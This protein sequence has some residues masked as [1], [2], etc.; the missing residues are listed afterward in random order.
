LS[1]NQPILSAVAIY[2]EYYGSAFP[3]KSKRRLRKWAWKRYQALKRA[4]QQAKRV[5]LLAKLVLSGAVSFAQVIDWFLNSQLVLYMG[6]LPFLYAFLK[7][8]KVGEI[9]NRYCPT[10]GDVDHGTVAMIMIINR[11]DA[12]RPLYKIKDWLSKTVLIYIVGVPASKFND[13]RLGRTLDAMNDHLEEIWQDIVAQALLR[14]EI[15][16]SI[17][18]YDLSAFIA[19]GEYADSEYV[20]FGFA[21]NTPMNKKKFKIGLDV[22]AAGNIPL[23]YKFWPGRSADKATVKTNMKALKEFLEK[24]NRSSKGTIIIG[25]RANLD[26]KLA[27]AYEKNQLRY[28][29]GLQA[30]KKNH[31]DLLEAIPEKYFYAN[32]LTNEEGS[33]GYW[34]KS[35]QVPFENEKNHRTIYHKG[36]VVLSGPMRTALR[37]DRAKKL[38]QTRK[39]LEKLRTK[40]GSPYFRGMKN[41]E[42][43]A[44]RILKKS[45]VGKL[46]RV[47][48]FLNND[49][50]VQLQ[51]AIDTY[52]L[53]KAMQ[54]DGRYLLV[55]NDQ[56]LSDKRMLELY[57][58]KD[59]VEKRFTVAKSDLKVSPI[60]LH[61]DKRIKAMLLLN[62]VALLTY[63]LI[64]KEI[65]SRGLHITTR[66][67]IQKLKNLTLVKSS[68]KGGIT[69][70][71]RASVDKEQKLLLAYLSQI[72][73]E[74]SS[75]FEQSLKF[76]DKK[77]LFPGL[78][79]P[80]KISLI[81]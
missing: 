8:L 70:C 59:G 50:K 6:T 71:K 55:T 26:D 30:H 41:I 47:E 5:A 79:P 4:N 27:F 19:H 56:S 77:Q 12:G 34:G 51:G 52:A 32:P 61:K 43:K 69:V 40:I 36:L 73:N 14:F 46:M 21:H 68:F 72:L 78:H 74:F 76:N 58:E 23:I 57:R 20:D 29:S 45:P 60:Y 54:R 31:K 37:K 35:C 25:D 33:Q 3:W 81:A 44:K 9:I 62:M 10:K 65:Q 11:L 67:I 75:K 63:S 24:H 17:V 2:D 66:S 38:H 18:F 53:R 15:D 28:L 7:K 13:D 64:E 22:S 48:A 49:G 1:Q 39:E 16:L 42:N 80:D